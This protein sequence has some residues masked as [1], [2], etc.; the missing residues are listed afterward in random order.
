ML[1]VAH[2]LPVAAG[3]LAALDTQRRD[4][5]ELIIRLFTEQLL[6]AVQRGLPR[7]YVA[8]E[9]NLRLL[10]GKLRVT[11]QVTHLAAWPDRLACRFDE[12]S[13]DTPLNRLLKAAVSRLRRVVRTEANARLL[14][15]L[16]ARFEAVG[17]SPHPLRAPVRL[18][19]TNATF[20]ALHTLARL[21]LAGEWQN[22]ASGGA[23]GFALLFPMNELFERFVRKSLRCALAPRSVRLQPAD[24]HALTG[25]NGPLFALRPDAT[26]E[27]PE[28]PVVLDTKWKSLSGCGDA[29]RRAIGRLSD[30]RLCAGL[31]RFAPDPALPLD[32]RIAAEG[33]RAGMDGCRKRSPFRGRDGRRGLPRRGR[34]RLAPH[35][36]R[37]VRYRPSRADEQPDGRLT[38]LLRG[39]GLRPGRNRPVTPPA[40]G[41]LVPSR[42]AP[43][44]A[45]MLLPSLTMLR[46]RRALPRP[47]RPLPGR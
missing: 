42:G 24:H 23:P 33:A 3:A 32:S 20:H 15:E 46:P 7:R 19:R 40:C 36:W 22:T 34:R 2:D 38:R 26:V 39:A 27:V 21:F 17:D 18:A 43:A 37:G 16:A 44:T 5:L 28:G 41:A 45:S 31:S 10:R 47:K 1:A 6:A 13:G 35:H 11:R 4:L 30:A 14:A 9:D 25:A 8:R 29:R 12:L